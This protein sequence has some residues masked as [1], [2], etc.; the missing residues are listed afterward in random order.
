VN[1]PDR[2]REAHELFIA[3]LSSTS[4]HRAVPACPAWD[5]HD[6][7]AHQVHQLRGVSDG[8]FPVRDSI[9]ALSAA[10]AN[11]RTRASERQDRW[12][13]DG[14]RARRT[15]PLSA[16]VDEWKELL[17]SAS[18]R[19]LTGLFPDVAVH[20][21]DLMGTVP[22]TAHR[23]HS[24]VVPAL[25]FWVEGSTNRLKRAGLG[26][27]RVELSLTAQ[28]DIVIG[29]VDAAI[30]MSGTPFELLRTLTG[31]RSLRQAQTL[32]WKGADARAIA[33]VPAYGWRSESLIE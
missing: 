12:I 32:R 9:D 4:E 16:L 5:V 13:G 2:Y 23:D 10:V 3:A 33:C 31:R 21:F 25:R 30:Q 29:E 14:V 28:P 26:A 24:I 11:E 22:S 6:L 8:A 7:L 1:E 20:L 18:P 27:L 15:T 17:V 19:A